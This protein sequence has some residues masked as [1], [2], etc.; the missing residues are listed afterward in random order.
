MNTPLAWCNLLH[1]RTRTFVALCGVA[2]AVILVLM[3][4]GFLFSVLASAT[5][6][7][8]QLEFDL[9]LLAPHYRF[10]SDSGRFPG[11]RLTQAAAHPDV[12]DTTPLW[13][14]S[15]FWR[16]LDTGK[17]RAVLLVGFNP[18]DRPFRLPAIAEAQHL[19][20]ARDDVLMDT[21]SR[22]EF[23]PR[24]PGTRAEVGGHAIRVVGNFALGTGFGADGMLL[25]SDATYAALAPYLPPEDYSLGLVRLRPGAN[26]PLVQRALAERLPEDV[27]VWTRGQLA[28]HERFHWVVKT[29]VGW[30]IGLGVFVAVIVGVAIVYQVLSSD[31]AKNLAE[32]AT[33]KA[34]GY[35]PGYLSKVVLQQAVILAV[36]GF[37]PGLVV[38]W[39]LYALIRWLANIPMQMGPALAGGVLVLSV[40]MCVLSGYASLRKVVSADPADL[41]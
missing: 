38:S 20:T 21:V 13:I 17:E 37:V 9:V 18:V 35:G 41:F 36:A 25:C 40:A 33:L 4:L 23:G 6:V 24:T 5:R 1:D 11:V 14:S 10:M 31:I 22:P 29:S 19:L 30:I 39:L 2:F 34:M 7:Y 12:L 16:R 26:A 8:D 27:R 32:Y 3:Q 28:A 15:G